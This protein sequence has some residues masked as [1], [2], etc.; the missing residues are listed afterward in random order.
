MVIKNNFHAKQE[1]DTLYHFLFLCIKAADHEVLVKTVTKVQ[2]QQKVVV[3]DKTTS[4]D[5]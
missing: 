1:A 2:L 4:E 5:Q 3:Q